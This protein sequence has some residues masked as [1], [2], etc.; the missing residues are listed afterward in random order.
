MLA[1][2]IRDKLRKLV[3][4]ELQPKREALRFIIKNKELP[5]NTR[6]KAQLE[7]QTLPRYSML[8]G[9]EDRC[10]SRGRTRN[11]KLKLNPIEFRNQALNGDLPG[12]KR[13]CW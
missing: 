1:N 11:L 6:I 3:S 5:L 12:I 10:I 9:I 4:A 8:V 2:I 13:S 7:L